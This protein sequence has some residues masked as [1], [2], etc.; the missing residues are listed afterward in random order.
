MKPISQRQLRCTLIRFHTRRSLAWLSYDCWS[1]MS[2][3][4]VSFFAS[5][6]QPHSQKPHTYAFWLS[7]AKKDTIRTRK[8]CMREYLGVSNVSCMKLGGILV[9]AQAP[10]R[11]TLIEDLQLICR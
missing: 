7:V 8:L 10:K 2:S 1:R 4:V 11:Q 9:A 5:G 6:K 3:H